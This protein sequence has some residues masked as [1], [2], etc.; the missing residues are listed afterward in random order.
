MVQSWG[1][2]NS[3]LLGKPCV[4]PVVAVLVGCL[5]K[6]E[7]RATGKSAL[8]AG[9]VRT[10]TVRC[11]F[12]DGCNLACNCMYICSNQQCPATCQA[13]A[14]QCLLMNEGMNDSTNSKS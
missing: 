8:K 2:L 6:T 9:A 1:S 10:N 4:L 5:T 12:G 14:C 11:R 7:A 13:G 3:L